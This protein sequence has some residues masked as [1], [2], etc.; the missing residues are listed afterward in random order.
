[1][2]YTVLDTGGE[3]VEYLRSKGVEPAHVKDVI[4]THVLETSIPP[5]DQVKKNI[6]QIESK[7]APKFISFAEEPEKKPSSNLQQ[8]CINL[9][10]KFI[11]DEPAK[12]TGR[13]SETRELVEKFYLKRT[14]V[15]LY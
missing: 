8:Y 3:F 13:D 1:M 2:L 9:N 7:R 15:M 11:T 6:L 14:K 10:E 5:T 12:I 4:E